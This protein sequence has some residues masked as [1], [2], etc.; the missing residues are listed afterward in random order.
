M[1]FCYDL[2]D[3][4]LAL[5]LYFVWPSHLC[6]FYM[7]GYGELSIIDLRFVLVELPTQSVK[8]FTTVFLSINHT[9]TNFYLV[10]YQAVISAKYGRC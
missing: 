5:T 2:D 8:E 7:N 6:Y 4:H 10:S 1:N 9:R 3:S